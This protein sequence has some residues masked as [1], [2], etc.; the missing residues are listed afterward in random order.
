M[1]DQRSR[2]PEELTRSLAAA[3]TAVGHPKLCECHQAMLVLSPEHYAIY[4]EA[5]WHRDQITKALHQA[6]LRPASEVVFGAGGIG[7]GVPEAYAKGLVPK[8]T[9]N[10]LH[11]IRAGGSAGLYSAIL[12]GWPGHRAHRESHPV[13][14]EIRL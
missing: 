7:E 8:F 2:T 10:G 1:V 4:R 11:L 9:P 6:L 5:G 3:L 12:P 13:T 14:K